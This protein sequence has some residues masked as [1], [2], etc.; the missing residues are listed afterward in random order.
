MIEVIPNYNLRLEK[1]EGHYA[2][3]TYER[4]VIPAGCSKKIVLPYRRIENSNNYLNFHISYELSL[5]G[6]CCDWSNLNIKGSFNILEFLIRNTNSIIDNQNNP[7]A[8]ITK[9]N[10]RI[11][12]LPNTAFG[13]IHTN[14]LV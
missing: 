1:H 14:S 12:I 9:S 13:A 11:D 4:F 5:H 10:N 6:I 7:L 2:I 3:F 8:S